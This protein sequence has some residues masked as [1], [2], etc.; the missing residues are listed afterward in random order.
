M[1]TRLIRAGISLLL[2]TLPVLMIGCAT[3]RPLSDT[4]LTI[5]WQRL[6]SSGGTC[7]RCGET[8]RSL[9]EAERVLAASLKP[10]GMR[11]RIVKTEITPADFNRD[12]SESNRIWIGQ[13]PL[14]KILGA[15]VSTSTCTG[16]CGDSPCRTVIIDGQT[17]EAIPAALIVRAGLRVAADQ[18]NPSD[19]NKPCCA[20]GTACPTPAGS[21]L[22]PMPWLTQQP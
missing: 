14:E 5:R 8:E 18:V 1:T 20:P 9:A 17:Y 7:D 12:P 21:D 13:E 6:V 15:Q 2:S 4:T 10:L 16:C 19:H 3:A 11:V 22:Q